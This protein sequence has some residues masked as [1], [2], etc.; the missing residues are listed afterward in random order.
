LTLSLSLAAEKAGM[1]KAGR[2]GTLTYFT[3]EFAK[4]TTRLFRAP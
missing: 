3:M 1:E 4:I 2:D